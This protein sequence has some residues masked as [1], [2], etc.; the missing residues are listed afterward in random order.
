MLGSRELVD[1]AIT[2]CQTTQLAG[3]LYYDRELQRSHP[4]RTRSQID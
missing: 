3:D 1:G 2:V 4:N